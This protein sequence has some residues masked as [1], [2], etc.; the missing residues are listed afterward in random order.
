MVSPQ[1]GATHMVRTWRQPN[2]GPAWRGIA[3]SM[4]AA[5]FVGGAC[6]GGQT[7]AARNPIASGGPDQACSEAARA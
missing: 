5:G 2:H 3:I 1:R 7:T 4:L 6:G